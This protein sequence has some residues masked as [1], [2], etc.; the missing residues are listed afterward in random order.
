MCL[1]Q[2]R[3]LRSYLEPALEASL[4][5]QFWDRPEPALAV[6]A[7]HPEGT[8]GNVCSPSRQCRRGLNALV[9]E[10]INDGSYVT[11]D[12]EAGGSSFRGS[13][14]SVVS[15]TSPSRPR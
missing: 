7:V 11:N 2:L 8:R 12:P 15:S 14:T 5:H 3:H 9:A 10:D 13:R 6:T 1:R 4:A